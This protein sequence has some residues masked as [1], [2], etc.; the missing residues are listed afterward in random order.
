M[1]QK[2]FLLL[3]LPLVGVNIWASTHDNYF[4]IHL[5]MLS[6]TVKEELSRLTIERD[7][8]HNSFEGIKQSLLLMY[9]EENIR[10]KMHNI[11]AETVRELERAPG[12]FREIHKLTQQR[13][14]W[15]CENPDCVVCLQECIDVPRK[16]NKHCMHF[17]C[18]NCLAL[19]IQQ[20]KQCPLCREPWTTL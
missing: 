10:E 16:F 2:I 7:S 1:N 5:E 15:L 11:Y 3:I 8:M 4:R 19:M 6:Q 18:F 14:K 17:V 13:K 12:M 20:N 9:A